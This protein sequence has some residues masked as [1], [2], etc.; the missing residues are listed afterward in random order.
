MSEPE[1]REK[2]S[3]RTDAAIEALKT[4]RLRWVMGISQVETKLKINEEKYRVVV[5]NVMKD[6]IER[7]MMINAIK[8]KGPLTIKEMSEATDISPSR[9]LRHIIALRKAGTISEVGEKEHGY[10]YAVM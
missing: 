9:I 10:L 1:K 7:Q 3:K 4:Q 8:Q 6:E 5:D 2:L